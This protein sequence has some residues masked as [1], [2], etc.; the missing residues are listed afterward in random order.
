MRLCG[1]KPPGL[2][3]LYSSVSAANALAR[4]D[5]ADPADADAAIADHVLLD[6]KAL[7]P[8]VPFD[9]ARRAIAEFWVDVFVPE[10]EGLEN[11]AVR[12]DNVVSACHWRPSE[13]QTISLKVI[14]KSASEHHSEC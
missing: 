14:P 8:V 11:V 9:D 5:P 12:I 10:I 13:A 7:L 4:A 6:D 3:S 1:S 2:P